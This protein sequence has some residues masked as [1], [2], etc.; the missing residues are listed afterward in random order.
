MP[1]LLEIK[2][3]IIG[4]INPVLA[5][6]NPLRPFWRGPGNIN[7]HLVLHSFSSFGPQEYLQLRVL[8][9]K[10]QQRHIQVCHIYF[11]WIIPVVCKF[12]KT[13]F[14][15]AE[16]NANIDV[17]IKCGSRT[18]KTRLDNYFGNGA[19]DS[20]SGNMIGD[21]DGFTCDQELKTTL[22]HQ[23]TDGWKC[24]YIK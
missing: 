19:V 24:D 14:V 6:P 8:R 11:S 22:I 1:I 16:S 18:C 2:F 20:F 3:H 10:L 5:N 7:I 23:G 4:A 9:P 12:Y 17:L 13:L 21:C 15:C